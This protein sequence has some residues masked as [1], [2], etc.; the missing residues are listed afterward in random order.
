MRYHPR[1]AV[2]PEKAPIVAVIGLA[3]LVGSAV[4]AWLSSPATLHLTR[5]N[6]DRVVAVIEARLFGLVVSQADRVEGIRSASLVHFDRPGQPSH[7]PARLVFETRQGAVDLGRNQ[8]LFAVDYGDID[9]FF[10][11][12]GPST[13]TL[14]SIA[15]GS[16]LRRFVIAQAIAVFLCLGGLGLGWM[17]ISS[18]RGGWR[19]APG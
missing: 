9:G 15:R 2:E 10:K 1:V 13:L 6:E 4:L 16:E 5:D 7:T 14:S 8:Q 11:T 12:S 19:S 3:W 18:L 17:L